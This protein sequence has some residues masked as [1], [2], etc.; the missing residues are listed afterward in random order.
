MARSLGELA[1]ITRAELRGNPDRIIERVETLQEAT[2]G[3]IS[4]LANPRYRGFLRNTSASAVIVAPEHV[5]D[6]PVDC[7]VSENP[8]LAHARATAA[9]YP[10]PDLLPGVHQTATVE[11]TAQVSRS[12]QIGANAYI[13]SGA[14][15]HDDVFVGPGCM[16]LQ[17]A[18]IGA[19]SRLIAAVTLGSETRLGQRCLIHP[20]AV[21]GGDGFG[22]ANDEGAWVKVPQIGRAVLGDDV[23]VGSCS[24]IDRGAIGDTRIADGVKIDSQVHI[25][26][27]VEVGMHTAMAGCSAVAGSTRIGAYCT[28]AGG[29]GVTGHVE[30]V[31]H[32]HVS[33][34][35]AITRSM[36]KPG[37][38]TGTVPAMEHS[39]WL[40]NFARLR[41]LDDMVRKV[42]DMEQEIRQ[43]RDHLHSNDSVLDSDI[44]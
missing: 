4:F 15:V 28:L 40:K 17:G 30:L 39:A 6:C 29:A 34:M 5:D 12:A 9:L 44:E 31:D 25:A 13:G 21:I 37:V 1:T 43:L 41:H 27:N 35:T 10:Y 18:E 2:A 11:P 24:S 36:K 16:V 7:L 19:G 14:V 32:V 22:L 33:G 23:E 3:A 20:G 42:R 8:Y 38:Y 26:H